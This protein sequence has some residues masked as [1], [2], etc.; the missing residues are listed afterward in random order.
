MMKNW[1]SGSLKNQIVWGT[2]GY[3]SGVHQK[4][5]V[6]VEAWCRAKQFYIQ[7]ASLITGVAP[8]PIYN[9]Y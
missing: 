5:H 2:V 3:G 4:L 8:L 9:R 6:H 1:P 7:Y